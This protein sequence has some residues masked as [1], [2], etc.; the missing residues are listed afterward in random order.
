[1]KTL[2]LS[3]EEYISNHQLT[4]D[5]GTYLTVIIGLLTVYAVA[6]AFY[7]FAASF[8][9][10]TGK[11]PGVYLGIDLVEYHMKKGLGIYSSVISSRLFWLF[12]A[13][14]VLYKPLVNVWG[15]DFSEKAVKV[16]NFAWYAYCVFFFL[17]FVLFFSRCTRAVM[18]LNSFTAHMNTEDVSIGEHRIILNINKKIKRDTGLPLDKRSIDRLAEKLDWIIAGIDSTDPKYT[19]L[20]ITLIQS[21]MWDYIK[22]KQRKIERVLSGS[23]KRKSI[24]YWQ[25]DFRRESWLLK[26]LQNV[27]IAARECDKNID[28]NSYIINQHLKMLRLGMDIARAKNY[29][30]I[31]FVP[32]SIDIIG[33]ETLECSE[34]SELTDTL[35]EKGS[36]A[37]KKTLVE[38]LYIYGEDNNKLTALYCK[39]ALETFIIKYMDKTI[40]EEFSEKDFVSVFRSAINTQKYNLIFAERLRDYMI[41]DNKFEAADLIRLLDK[42]S[43]TYIFVYLLI[44][45]SVYDFRSEWAYINIKM[46]DALMERVDDVEKNRDEIDRLLKKSN[47][48]HRY[49]TEILDVLLKNINERITWKWL[50]EIYQQNKINPFYLTAVKLCVFNQMY[51]PYYVQRN[52]EAEILFINSLVKHPEIMECRNVIDMIQMLHFEEFGK[53]TRI[54]PKLN[55]TLRSLLLLDIYL[56]DQDLESEKLRYLHAGYIGQYLLVMSVEYEDTTQTQKNY[57]KKAYEMSDKSV[58]EY[59]NNLYEECELCGKHLNY[60]KKEKLRRT[61]IDI[62]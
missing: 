62:I 54:P 45:Y 60:S 35:F 28:S 42:M 25:Y 4:I 53:L 22:D 49:K 12:F 59:V 57:I 26:K 41:A 37:D 1:M 27:F 39:K 10:E 18:A 48:N 31:S 44:F 9:G 50:A 20:Y 46:L 2:C 51:E 61:L 52:P 36:L 47:I 24:A 17:F 13:A 38:G 33:E 23:K 11:R 43:R 14:A 8:Y 29:K 16:F 21:L 15:E 56:T 19:S 6:L 30:N 3:I 40:S 34:W 5:R 32:Y 55:I 58:D 7:Q